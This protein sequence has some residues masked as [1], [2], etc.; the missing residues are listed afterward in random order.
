MR[1]SPLQEPL[2]ASKT[3]TGYHDR[4]HG[5]GAEGQMSAVASRRERIGKGKTEN[6]GTDLFFLRSETANIWSR[7]IN[8]CIKETGK[9]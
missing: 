5:E 4:D 3:V 9:V 6:R 2:W 1:P 8:I 7:F